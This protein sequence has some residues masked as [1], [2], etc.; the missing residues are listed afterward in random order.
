MLCFH[1]IRDCRWPA[2]KGVTYKHG[3]RNITYNTKQKAAIIVGIGLD[4]VGCPRF[5]PEEEDKLE[6]TTWTSETGVASNPRVSD[7][8]EEAFS[9]RCSLYMQQDYKFMD[10]QETEELAKWSKFKK[11]S[12][13]YRATVDRKMQEQKDDD[14]M[15]EDSSLGSFS[16]MQ[17]G[18]EMCNDMDAFPDGMEDAA[19]LLT[20]WE[21]SILHRYWDVFISKTKMRTDAKGNQRVTSKLSIKPGV[22]TSTAIRFVNFDLFTVKMQVQ[23]RM[24]RTPGLSLGTR[25]DIEGA[26][27]TA[28]ACIAR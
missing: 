15:E 6:G 2:I 5:R 24:K 21:V 14:D 13:S 17:D 22:S 12:A 28:K 16:T 7:E 18:G 20:N 3:S 10:S 19:C 9:E 25:H 23:Q 26:Y 8:V 4:M 1:V 27:I 11:Q